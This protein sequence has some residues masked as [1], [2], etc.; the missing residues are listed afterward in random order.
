[1]MVV[2]GLVRGSSVVAA[3]ADGLVRGSS[4][5]A[6]VV[7]VGHG[8]VV[9][10]MLSGVDGVTVPLDD[11]VESVVM[12]SSVVDLP[13]GSIGLVQAVGALDLVSLPALLGTLDITGMRIVDFVLVRVVSRSLHSGDESHII[14]SLKEPVESQLIVLVGSSSR[15][16][17]LV[18]LSTDLQN[19]VLS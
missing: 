9:V 18:N 6:A 5:V 7:V 8:V 15:W 14:C 10:R 13:D 4:V 17:Y 1:M 3:V 11:G 19:V 16:N 12:V 2:D